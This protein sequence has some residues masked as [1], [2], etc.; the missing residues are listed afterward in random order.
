VRH[1][2]TTWVAVSASL[3]FIIFVARVL[4]AQSQRSERYT[5][6]AMSPDSSLLY[7]PRELYQAAEAY[8]P[9]GRTAYVTARFTFDLVWPL[10]YAFFLSTGISWLLVRTLPEHSL[11][12]TANL[13][14]L[15]AASFDAMENVATSLV[16]VRYPART[17]GIAAAAPVFTFLKWLLIG[18]SFAFLL[19]GVLLGLLRAARENLR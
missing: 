16:M 4:P 9:D 8:G 2:S 6:G 1:I 15:F 14:P 19:I 17:P 5:E 10:A 3:L 18:A 12:Q 11:W 13:T 7:A